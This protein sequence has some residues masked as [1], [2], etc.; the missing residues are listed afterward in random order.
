M[1][2]GWWEQ[3]EA[4][5]H[6]AI[7]RSPADRAAYLDE[8]C[9]GNPEM[10]QQVEELLACHGEA[11]DFLECPILA[12]TPPPAAAPQPR[13][14]SFVGQ[15]VGNYEILEPLGA[16]GMGEVYLARDNRLG[17]RVALKLLPRHS[18]QTADQLRRFEREA[19]VVSA[20][21]H[22]N[23]I[24][25]YEIGQEGDNHFIATEFVT[26]RTIR[27]MISNGRIE[28]QKAVEIATQLAHALVAAHAAGIVHRDIKP[29]N[30]MVRKDGLVK[31]LDF[32][33]AK[34]YS[35]ERETTR[36]MMTAF[37]NV[38]TNPLLILGTLAY[39]SPEQARAEKVD[40]RTDLFSLGV[41]LYEMLLGRRPFTGRTPGETLDAILNP[42]PVSIPA[43]E[44]PPKLAP[45]LALA[46]QKDRAHR[47]QTAEHI[48]ADL[49]N[50]L[51]R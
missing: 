6:L 12:K 32:G 30:L 17:R 11:N 42:A 38:Q 47:Y 22:P 10:R 3:I 21:N 45:I 24:T 15:T 19:R 51:A 35:A 7:E 5:F 27:E 4:I 37:N 25:L 31:V 50:F 14:E 33:L 29:E 2:S 40:Y 1:S 28:P 41:V 36:L 18:V 16:G 44:I 9:A 34:P 49:Q 8:A 26:G 48:R 43:D 23:I 39:L 20:L 46:L 13:G